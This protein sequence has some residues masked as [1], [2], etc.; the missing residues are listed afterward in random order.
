MEK[1][2][3]VVPY[4]WRSARIVFVIFCAQLVLG[5]LLTIPQK[6]AVIVHQE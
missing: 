3:A 1:M 5:K 6:D 2:A 4:L